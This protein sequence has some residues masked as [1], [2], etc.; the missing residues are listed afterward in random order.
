MRRL[1]FTI[2]F[3]LIS[4]CC[5]AQYNVTGR[6][7][8]QADTKPVANVSVFLSNATIGSITDTNGSFNLSNIKPGNYTLVISVVGFDSYSQIITINSSNI[9]LQTLT[10]YP[11]SIALGEVKIKANAGA[12]PERP[13]YMAL[14][15]GEFLGNTDIAKECKIL[16]PELLDFNY[17][18]ANSALTASSIDFLVIENNA[19]GYKIKYLLKNFTL[20]F[21]EDGTRAFAYSGSVLFEEMKGSPSQQKEWKRRRQEVYEGSQ[22]HFLRSAMAGTIEQDGFRILRLPANPQRPP[23]SVVQEKLR[24]YQALKNDKT[25]RDSLKYW[26][27]KAELPKTLDKPDPTPLKKEDIIKGPDRRGI[28]SLSF[29]GDALFVTYNKYHHFNRSARSKLSDPENKDNT[30]VSFDHAKLYF[31]RNGSV[32]NPNGLSFDGVWMRGRLATLLPLDYEP[33]LDNDTHT[34]ADSNLMKHLNA[35][36]NTYKTNHIIEKAYLQFDKPYYATGDTIYFKAYV[37]RG[38]KHEPTQ[39]SGILH[40]D[41]IGADNKL[42]RSLK[43]QLTDG[44]AWGD[45]ALAD[46]LKDG[47]YRVRAYTNFMQNDG[48]DYFFDQTIPVAS[49]Q[50]KKRPESG[51]FQNS[52]AKPDVQFFAEGGTLINGLKSKIAFK[53]VAPDGLGTV[54]KGT[55][56]DNENNV[57]ATFASNQLGMGLVE[58]TPKAGK[59]YH[60][61]IVY[62]D[63]ITEAIDLPRADDSGYQLN[64]DNSDK[65]FIVVKVAGS[66][67]NLQ[68]KLNLVAQ[69]GGVIYY[70]AQSI[71]GSKIFRVTISKSEF[72]TGIIQFTLFTETG[73]PLNERLIFVNNNDGLK[74]DVSADKVIYNARQK[75]SISLAAKNKNDQ[76]VKGSFSVA[77]T[78]ETKV[79]VNDDDGN[80]ILAD[81]LLTSDLKRTIENPN[82]YFNNIGPKTQADLDMLML[83]QGYRHFE[84]KQIMSGGNQAIA[85]QPERSLG[86]SGYVKTNKGRPVANAKVSL[87]T[88]RGGAFFIDTLTDAN[89][90][91]VFDNL[92]FDDS[93]KFVVQS[94]VK[95][96]QDDVVLDLDSISPPQISAKNAHTT[97]IQED[98][99]M[100]TYLISQK[101]FYQEQLKY[102]INQHSIIMKEVIIR[103]K[104]KELIP[105]SA[106]LNGNGAADQIITEKELDNLPCGRFIDC[107][108]AKL[109]G[110]IFKDG[111]LFVRRLLATDPTKLGIYTNP[112]LIIVDGTVMDAYFLANVEASQVAGVEVLMG[113]HFSAIYGSR[114]AGGAIVVTTKRAKPLNN[115]Y[116]Y[117][118]GVVT[119]KPIGFYKAR[120]FYSPQYD[121]PKTNQKM[122]DLRSTIYWKPDIATDK[123]GKASFEYFNADSKGIYRVVIEGIDADGNPG[124]QVYR[125]KVE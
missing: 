106:N 87:F 64:I 78:D 108:Q 46:T 31:D 63:G 99:N 90:R 105:H 101:Q 33:Q 118:P 109:S 1:T 57:V 94:R 111:M 107:L 114:G 83:T 26:T 75:V 10:I 44:F 6:I 117:A 47:N 61:N 67:A 125:Y 45:F 48:A 68:T 121:N 39:L 38:E 110:I 62:T 14:F 17:D 49:L 35:K 84:W 115:Y 34:E 80:G 91:F 119:Y 59:K 42:N 12:D 28:Y 56:A 51:A 72:P 65:N 2:S 85:Y 27:K 43:L 123:D 124:R 5:F 89:G 74:I 18:G 3:I 93:T 19:L 113:P 41:L 77:V 76:P 36:L 7:I 88:T 8:S 54:I 66:K 9:D 22:M 120:E 95:R 86:I 81:M 73:E 53:A 4:L 71:P 70:A 29:N 55:V 69:M 16:N 11:K 100:D 112:M 116:R 97:A 103:E 37:N 92:T 15:T 79:P 102:G 104:K 98:A 13:R 20:N 23:D 40:V 25:F 24:L 32:I 21:A 60:A 122:T 52:H 58:L 30:L 50:S 82:Y 96:G